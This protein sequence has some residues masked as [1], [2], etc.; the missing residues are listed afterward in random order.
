MATERYYRLRL[1]AL[2]ASLLFSVWAHAETIETEGAAMI[3]AGG[4]DKARQLAVQDAL[5]KAEETPGVAVSSAT[6]RSGDGNLRETSRVRP[7]GNA[8]NPAILHEWQEAGTLY[9]RVRSDVSPRERILA[10]RKKIAIT[11]FYVANPLQVQD[12]DNIWNG[13][14]LALLRLI[15]DSGLFLPVQT[16]GWPTLGRLALPL[17]RAQNR[18]TVRLLADQSGAQFVLSG[19]IYDAGTDQPSGILPKIVPSSLLPKIQPNNVGARRI[20]AEIFLHDGITGALISHFRAQELAPGTDA[21][22]RDKP[23][24][25]AAFFATGF[26]SA[27]ARLLERQAQFVVDELGRLPFNA[28]IIRIE[29]NR[30]FFDAGATSG[31]ATGDKFLLYSLSSIADAMELSSNRLLGV[32]EKPAATLTVK[33]VQPLFSVGESDARNQKIQIGDM[34]RFDPSAI[35]REK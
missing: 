1:L 10:F 33:Q 19:I 30:L 2:V 31:L 22:G 5:R 17:D 9:V 24:G 20:E 3:D 28:K 15:E 23:F 35:S 11:Q 16:S 34:I 18:E 21:V 6:V 32:A 7:L 12:I 29:G 8:S 14:P 13:Y 26:G 25:S 27:V 4:M